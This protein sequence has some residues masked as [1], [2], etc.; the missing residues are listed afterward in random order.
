MGHGPES[1]VCLIGYAKP[2]LIDSRSFRAFF[3]RLTGQKCSLDLLRYLVHKCIEGYQALLPFSSKKRLELF[4]RAGM[5]HTMTPIRHLGMVLVVSSQLRVFALCPPGETQFE[6][7]L[8]VRVLF[9]L[10]MKASRAPKEEI[11]EAKGN[12]RVGN[13][14]FPTPPPEVPVT[15]TPSKGRKLLQPACRPGQSLAEFAGP[16]GKA[17]GVPGSRPPW[18]GSEW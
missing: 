10:P 9:I 6:V 1:P 11:Q 14:C 15:R 17:A 5:G 16:G 7:L 4:G 8:T 13:L 2:I 12:L 3:D 18:Q